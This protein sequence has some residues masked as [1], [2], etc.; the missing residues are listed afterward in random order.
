MRHRLIPPRS[1]F[2]LTIANEG[3]LLLHL[4]GGRIQGEW[5]V[6]SLD[7]E[8]LAGLARRLAATPKAPLVVVNDLLEQSYRRETVPRLNWMDRAKVLRRRLESAFPDAALKGT[9]TLGPAADDARGQSH[10]LAAV[11]AGQD[12]SRWASFLR[13]LDNPITG[14]VLL[15]IEVTELVGRIARAAAPAGEEPHRWTVLVSRQRVGGFRQVVVH[16]GQLVL[17]RLT[18]SMP[19]DAPAADVAAEIQRELR[20]TLGYMTRLGYRAGGGL[21]VIVLGPGELHTEIDAPPLG[22]RLRVLEASEAARLLDLQLFAET[23]Q[24]DGTQLLAAWAGL[25]HRPT[26]QLLPPDLRARMVRSMALRGATAALAASALGLVSY[27]ALSAVTGLKVEQEITWLDAWQDTTRSKVESTAEETDQIG[28]Q[29]Q[30]MRMVLAAQ[31]QLRADRHDPFETLQALRSAMTREEQLLALSWTLAESS[32]D[33]ARDRARPEARDFVLD[34]TLDLRHLDDPAAAV[35]ATDKLAERLG[36]AFSNRPVT[37]TRQAVDILPHQAFIG[38]D[39]QTNQA[40]G[41][42]ATMSADLVIGRARP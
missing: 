39:G 14:V 12:W 40:G 17:T 34:L 21:D 33:Q 5:C 42:A 37:V 8:A 23:E 16:Q 24:A 27:S 30:T 7:D 3:G 4:G 19:A 26:L 10:L 15:P 28:A 35:A 32:P 38:G 25:K 20:A 18:P 29:A 36:A 6:T 41:G 31:R 9:L 2:V 1:R 11:P 22:A 13:T